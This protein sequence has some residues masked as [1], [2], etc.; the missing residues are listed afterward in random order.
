MNF[1]SVMLAFTIAT[2]MVLFS[3]N[4]YALQTVKPHHQNMPTP[5]K[6]K[7]GHP[8]LLK[9]QHDNIVLERFVNHHRQHPENHL[10][11]L[12]NTNVSKMFL[13]NDADIKRLKQIIA[14]EQNDP[15]NAYI[16][17]ED[18]PDNEE[19]DDLISREKFEY[20][21]LKKTTMLHNAITGNLRAVYKETS[22]TANAL[23]TTETYPN[24]NKMFS[25]TTTLLSSASTTSAPQT[26]TTTLPQT[27]TTSTSQTTTTTA[28]QTA[29]TS[30]PQT[31]TTFSATTSPI[32]QQSNKNSFI[33]ENISLPVSRS[34]AA[35]VNGKSSSVKTSSKQIVNNTAAKNVGS[36]MLARY[37]IVNTK[38]PEKNNCP[39][40]LTMFAPK[41]KNQKCRGDINMIWAV[42]TYQSTG[43]DPINYNTATI[44]NPVQTAADVKP[45]SKLKKKTGRNTPSNDNIK[46]L[47]V[48]D[49][50]LVPYYYNDANKI[51]SDRKQ[52]EHD[53]KAWFMF[54]EILDSNDQKGKIG[55]HV[56]NNNLNSFT[57]KGLVLE[58]P[59]HLSFPY[60]IP[61]KNE[62]YMTTSGTSGIISKP[63][64]LWLYKAV[65][66]P[67]K[68]GR[69]KMILDD[70]TDSPPVD[71]AIIVYNDVY[72][73]FTRDNTLNNG[74][75]M[76]RLFYNTNGLYEGRY[77]EHPMSRKYN[78]RQSGRIVFNADVIKP[79]WVVFHHTDKYV[80]GLKLSNLT[81]TTYRYDFKQ[82]TL[83]LAPIEN[84]NFAK[85]GMHTLSLV[86]TD[87]NKWVGVC[88]GWYDDTD[89]KIMGCLGRGWKA[90]RCQKK[91]NFFHEKYKQSNGIVQKF[92]PGKSITPKEG[93]AKERELQ[94]KLKGENFSRLPAISRR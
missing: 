82:Q 86:R 91:A 15:M 42:A 45:S 3:F 50:F 19:V 72:Y 25:R 73:L 14:K 10:F 93:T 13:T 31:T 28:P 51:V 41:L 33:R 81:T 75:G 22:H 94:R 62:F 61:Y 57:F 11:D 70:Q 71:P 6:V 35:N 23:T 8:D 67:Y 58:E 64:F 37:N 59:W 56:S 49:P 38:N 84:S 5:K 17:Q 66:Y 83:L 76:E 2:T 29:T 87:K 68:W 79:H 7:Y 21:L 77:V 27:A 54:T 78:V 48:A 80:Y 1:T 52:Y 53:N 63:Y 36:R 34:A 43:I 18:D 89:L 4:Y 85:N 88:D 92:E 20:D 16:M 65:K 44:F 90:S 30:T 69:F 26:A 74:E 9:I 32:L 55:L 60:I 46:A 40:R 47:F 12:S 24:K 39:K